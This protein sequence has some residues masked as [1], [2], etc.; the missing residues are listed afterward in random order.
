MQF[1]L[2]EEFD[3]EEDVNSSGYKIGTNTKKACV[4]ILKSYFL[5]PNNTRGA[6]QT[7]EI[8]ISKYNDKYG[9]S[10]NPDDYVLHHRNGLHSINDFKNVALIRKSVINH[11]SFHSD[12][13]KTLIFKYADYKGY[14][15]GATIP[16]HLFSGMSMFDQYKL[17]DMYLQMCE[18]K[19]DR[20][21]NKGIV[22]V[23]YASEL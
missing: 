21:K 4:N 19:T 6:T 1:R 5:Q 15:T 14:T 9:A 10:L 3:L 13:I 18:L 7:R 12:I 11:T 20:K 8:L 22:D 17:L 2:V 23:I 16:P